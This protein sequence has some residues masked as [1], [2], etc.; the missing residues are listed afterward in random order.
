VKL[1]N[2]FAVPL[3][4]AETLAVLLDVERVMTC[5][6][7]A[8]LLEVV[9]DRTYR[10]QIRV[11]LGPIQM[12]FKGTVRIEERDEVTRRVRLKGSGQETSGRGAA[13]ADILFTLVPA[14][15]VTNVQVSTDLAL[16]GA[17]VQYGRGGG[18]IADVS[19]HLVAQFADRLKVQIQGSD[20]ERAQADAKS[21]EAISALT[22]ARVGLAG[23]VRRGLGLD[24]G[25]DDREP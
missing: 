16:T 9:D 18:M 19:R 21:R 14:D 17:V 10:A 11:R 13:Q 12:V 15:A 1:E 20:E 25:D 22:I 5:L 23:V 2:T 4:P 3:G 24:Q 7:G 8:E 6:P